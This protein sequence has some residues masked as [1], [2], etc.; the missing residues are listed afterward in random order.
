[1]PVIFS[2]ETSYFEVHLATTT[3]YSS[4]YARVCV[5][6]CLH[7]CIYKSIW[8]NLTRAHVGF[9]AMRPFF[10]ACFLACFSAPG[11]L[12]ST[13]Y[14]TFAQ[15]DL[16]CVYLYSSLPAVVGQT[17]CALS[18]FKLI[19]P[20]ADRTLLNACEMVCS[21]KSMY[22]VAGTVCEQYANELKKA[23][24]KW[25]HYYNCQRM[26]RTHCYVSLQSTHPVHVYVL[27]FMCSRFVVI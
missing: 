5:G 23:I 10:V 12:Y 6:K 19:V 14:T 2:N 9:C 11:V 4:C 26:P 25:N 15:C 22:A 18:G 21:C 17:C 13:T 1:M 3:W 8:Q 20:Q 27:K 16:C 7:H 24:L